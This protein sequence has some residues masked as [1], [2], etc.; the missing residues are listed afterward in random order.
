MKTQLD[1][2]LLKIRQEILEKSLCDS[3][4][5]K[6]NILD[7]YFSSKPSIVSYLQEKYSFSNLKVLEIGSW[8]G[9]HLFYW[10]SQS[11]GIDVQDKAVSFTNSLGFKTTKIN[12][13]EGLGEIPDKS[14]DAI[15]TNDLIE[16]L[17]SP[18]LFL[19]HCFRVLKDDGLLA[20]G[21]PVVPPLFVRP[22][23]KA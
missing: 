21:H 4:L 3:D 16:H 6:K 17:V 1:Q 5:E 14:F 2:D 23:W 13:E 22:I 10:G 7:K 18:H 19:A 15:H 20:I 9:Q 11:E 12:V 8:L